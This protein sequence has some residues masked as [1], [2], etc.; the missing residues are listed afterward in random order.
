MPNN[1]EELAYD[2]NINPS[3]IFDNKQIGLQKELD[4][5]G[6]TFMEGS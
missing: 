3:E 6:R 4:F 1:L 2:V 5:I